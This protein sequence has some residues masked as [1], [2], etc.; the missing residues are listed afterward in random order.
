ADSRTA[1][2]FE[3]LAEV[4]YQFELSVAVGLRGLSD[5]FAVDAKGVLTV[6]QQLARR[7]GAEGHSPGSHFL[8]DRSRVFPAPLLVTCGVARRVFLHQ[9]LEQGDHFGFFLAPGGRLPPP[10]SA[11][12]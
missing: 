9:L 4:G 3:S 11:R 2:C 5:A 12:Q 10:G 1:G 8:T 7:I 6:L